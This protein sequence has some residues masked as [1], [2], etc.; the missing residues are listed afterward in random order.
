MDSLGRFIPHSIMR[1][2]ATLFVFV[3]ALGVLGGA[4]SGAAPLA[5]VPPANVI[6]V[7]APAAPAGLAGF[8]IDSGAPGVSSVP[9]TCSALICYVTLQLQNTGPGCAANIVGDV[10]VFTAPASVTTLLVTANSSIRIPNN[11]TMTSGQIATVNVALPI[12]VPA[13]S[14][15]V[16]AVLNWTNPTCP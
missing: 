11:P 14:Y 6:V 3:V 9:V 4:C 1:S 5:T 7:G 12:P 16:T 8:V 13:V 10:N 15:V 2:P